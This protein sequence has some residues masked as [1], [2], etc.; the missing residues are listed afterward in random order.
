MTPAIEQG[1]TEDASIKQT[2]VSQI[3]PDKAVPNSILPESDAAIK[4]GRL[5]WYHWL[6]VGLSLVIT[7]AAWYFA[8]QQIE[9][10]TLDRFHQE[11]GQVTEHV[12][13]RMEKYEDALWSGVAA[14]HAHGGNMSRS[15]WRVFAGVLQIERRYPG[16]S[17]IGVIYNV[18]GNKLQSFLAEQPRERPHF[19]IYP[20]HGKDTYLPITY[21]EPEES[22]LKAVGLDM[23]H[24]SNRYKA[25]QEARDS[26]EVQ[27]TGP[28]VLVQDAAK[29]PGFLIYAPFYNDD[30]KATE[31]ERQQTFKG[32]VYAPFKFR[33]L[34]K[35]VL[36]KDRREIRLRVADGDEELYDERGET[37][38]IADARF[39]TTIDVT[40]YGRAWTFTFWS[41][42]AF[43]ESTSNNQ[44]LIILG[45][46]IFI[47]SLLLIF[48]FMLSRANRRTIAFAEKTTRKLKLSVA[49]LKASNK[50]LTRS[51][52]EL[53]A[54]AYI[55]SHDLKE[56][57]RAIHNHSR[58]LLEDHAD[59]LGKDGRKRLNRLVALSQKTQK[60]VSD[61]LYFS[62]LGRAKE[63]V[64][65][66]NVSN[67]LSDIIANL[68][69]TF[70]EASAKISIETD[71]PVVTGNQAHVTTIFQNLIVNAIKYNESA[72]K[73]VTIGCRPKC[74]HMDDTF[75]NVFYVRDNG[76]GIP[77]K[78]QEQVFQIFKRL[79]NESAY[80]EGTGAGLAFVKKIIDS[81]R[82]RIWVESEEGRGATFYF[83]FGPIS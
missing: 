4:F 47:D 45:G 17:G 27:I 37:E 19:E 2:S 63:S 5:H 46:G 49:E 52:A 55:A 20:A 50:E 6:V 66:V 32:M 43:G 22:N 57:L 35:G 13:E 15:E 1:P 68:K 61:L 72:E 51:N 56:P 28:I 75:E 14:I 71:L 82:G 11:A 25:A 33:E 60:Q 3:P 77:M 36:G 42:P 23:V 59:S 54:F 18:P 34:M 73:E 70:I 10:E 44:P 16:I 8:K 7:F 9:G 78:F 31:T 62:R 40:L 83:T 12:I 41:T 58:F 79:H 76:I 74:Q 48:F 21:I 29:L 24:E 69:D 80:G 30:L 65:P 64:A 38:S 53:D 81:S 39:V 67:V 26:G